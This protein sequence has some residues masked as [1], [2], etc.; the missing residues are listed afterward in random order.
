M[1]REF[2]ISKPWILA[3]LLFSVTATERVMYG[4]AH[5]QGN[6]Q[7]LHVAGKFPLYLP[8]TFRSMATKLGFNVRQVNSPTYSAHVSNKPYPRQALAPIEADKRLNII[9]L[10][11][12]SLRADM[13]TQQ[14]MP[15]TWAFAKRGARFT[16][17]FSGGN[18]TRMGIFSMFYGL[19]GTYWQ[20]FLEQ[21]R[22]PVLVDQLLNAG[23]AMR[24]QTSSHF[25][26]P[27]FDKTVWANVPGT[28]LHE[29][30]QGA[31]WERDRRNVDRAIDWIAEQEN[32]GQ[33][34]FFFQFFESPHANYS[35][36]AESI[37]Q[38]P[39]LETFNYATLDVDRDMHLV[40]ARYINSVNHLD[41]QLGKLLKKLDESGALENTLVIITGDHGEEFMEN[42]HWGHNSAY[43]NAQTQVPLVIFAPQVKPQVVSSLTSH[44]DIAPTVLN[45]LGTTTP[46]DTY[47]LGHN[48][49]GDKS[50]N[51]TLVSG[52]NTSALFTHDY[53][54]SLSMQA[55]DFGEALVTN[56]QDQPIDDASQ[57][58]QDHSTRLA[59]LL[60]EMAMF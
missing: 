33:P 16:E 2:G 21:R 49:F 9:W 18:G 50:R 17:H 40:K 60:K 56:A 54:L 57:I 14:Y 7:I 4:I 8:T 27:E 58:Y 44:L 59:E 3:L 20:S 34:Y 19:Y 28:S 1:R 31:Y 41:Q 32:G 29:D 51:D 22:G 36:P 39:Y 24:M 30:D 47:S 23:Y 26:Y 10:V 11:S 53:K 5:A 42:G 46:A 12:E 38:E 48:L 25:T 55:F 37:V 6:T 52:W 15:N 45:L 43:T 35:F 13:L